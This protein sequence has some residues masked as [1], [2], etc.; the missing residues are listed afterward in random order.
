[1]ASE[2][3]RTHD[4]RGRVGSELARRRPIDSPP[5]GVLG[6]F[7]IRVSRRRTPRLRTHAH[8][9]EF[10]GRGRGLAAFGRGSVELTV[11]DMISTR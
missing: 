8:A 1:M 3:V 11:S 6:S 5:D 4:E 7:R 2:G 9:L 10:D